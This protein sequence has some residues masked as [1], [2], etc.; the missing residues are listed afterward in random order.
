MLSVLE[1]EVYSMEEF[2]VLSD[3]PRNKIVRM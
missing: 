3:V 1:K 2:G